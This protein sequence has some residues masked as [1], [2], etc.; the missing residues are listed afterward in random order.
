MRS[1]IVTF[2][3]EGI[4]SEDVRAAL[5]AENVNT[6]LSNIY[7]THINP[8]IEDLGT[9]IRASVHYITTDEEIEKLVNVVAGVA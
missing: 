5:T 4:A 3:R 8:E 2:S 9:F 7:R 1:G 6:S